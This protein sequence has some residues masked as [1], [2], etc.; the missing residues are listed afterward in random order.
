M[1]ATLAKEVH[2]PS[3]VPPGIGAVSWWSGNRLILICDF[4]GPKIGTWG[5]Q[6]CARR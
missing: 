4:P 6:R 2:A 3:E 1:K 5:T